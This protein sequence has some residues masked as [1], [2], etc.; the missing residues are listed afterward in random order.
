[1][2]LKAAR[3]AVLLAS[4]VSCATA[5]HAG[6]VCQAYSESPVEKLSMNDILCGVKKNADSILPCFED[7]KSQGELAPGKYKFIL[8][9]D[10]KPDGSAETAG[11]M[12]PNEF[13]NTPLSECIAT[14][15]NSQWLFRASNEG[16]PI[17]NFPFGPINVVN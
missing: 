7:A 12:G 4:S 17:K 13:L 8:R 15:I 10:I 3:I 14:T 1:M 5:Q 11:L 9:W 2:N 6:P 16:A